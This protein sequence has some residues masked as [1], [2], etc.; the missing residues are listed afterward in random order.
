MD[1]GVQRSASA[2]R[3]SAV[4]LRFLCRSPAVPL[5]FPWPWLL[6]GPSACPRADEAHPWRGA[7]WIF[8]RLYEKGLAYQVRP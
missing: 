1:A 5:P 7:Q 4:P 3:S 2:M 6:P 8:L